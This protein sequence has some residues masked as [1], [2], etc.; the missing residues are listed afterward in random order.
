[1][2]LGARDTSAVLLLPMRDTVEDE[3]DRVD[4][5]V[6]DDE[7]GDNEEGENVVENGNCVK[8]ELLSSFLTIDGLLD[9][10]VTHT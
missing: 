8:S 1:M 9:G 6:R 10:S 3:G 4:D 2:R 5:H 7:R